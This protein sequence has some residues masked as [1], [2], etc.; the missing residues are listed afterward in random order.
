MTLLSFFNE[1]NAIGIVLGV[2]DQG[3]MKYLMAGMIALKQKKL[4][5]GTWLRN[6]DEGDGSPFDF[7]IEAFCLNRYIFP[8]ALLIVKGMRFTLASLYLGSV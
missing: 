4:T 5:C 6:F 1:A 8:L 3:K 7:I 2:E